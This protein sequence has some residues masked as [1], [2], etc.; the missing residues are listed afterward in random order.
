MRRRLIFALILVNC[1]LGIALFARS[2]D[3]QIIPRGLFD[4]C[5]GAGSEGYCCN[6]CCW[7]SKNCES[8]QDCREN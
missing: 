2:A 8:D 7:F 6:N 1:L 5:Q 4:C 3:S